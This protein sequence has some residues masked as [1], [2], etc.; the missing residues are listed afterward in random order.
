MRELSLIYAGAN[1]RMVGMLNAF[2]ERTTAFSEVYRKRVYR[3]WSLGEGDEAVVFLPGGMAHGEVWFPQMLELR[4]I[5]RAVAFS[6]PECKSLEEAADGILFTLNQMGIGNIALVG[7]SLGGLIAQI[8]LRKSPGRVV[9]AA[10]CLTG[11]PSRDLPAAALER[12]KARRANAARMVFMNFNNAARMAMADNAFHSNCPEG[13]ETQL[14]FWRAFI[15]DTYCNHMYKKQY[16]N[17]NYVAQPDLYAQRPF[18]PGDMEGW[19]GRV[20]IMYSGEDK[21]YAQEQD[22]LRALY[23]G[24][25]L[26][27]LGSGGQFAMLVNGTETSR[28]VL[29]LV[30]QCFD[31][32]GE[33]A[34]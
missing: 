30:E 27:D 3:T 17:L 29:K 13:M 20:S 11:A 5:R 19:K 10:L 1:P 34:Q 9:G 14:D 32:K 12:W 25:Q 8:I 18:A 28:A 33:G 31:R 15:E 22:C 24:A 2:R 26:C 6:L 21:L 7:Y 16:V 23:P 4:G